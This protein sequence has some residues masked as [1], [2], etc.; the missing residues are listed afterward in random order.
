MPR[1]RPEYMP[2]LHDPLRLQLIRFRIGALL[3]GD[4]AAE[5]FLS[6][7]VLLQGIIYALPADTSGG[8]EALRVIHD[9]LGGDVLLALVQIPLG[10]LLWGCT[11]RPLIYSVAI[12][13]T[14]LLV[15][16]GWFSA[17]TVFVFWGFPFSAGT[18]TYGLLAALCIGTYLSIDRE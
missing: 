9:Q 13:R 16:F 6:S 5:C 10:L 2:P 4:D 7:Y 8:S 3:H 11:L 1:L 15:T 12:H 14:T 18:V 17:L